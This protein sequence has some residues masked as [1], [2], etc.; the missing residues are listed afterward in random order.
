MPT[1]CHS[2]SVAFQGPANYFHSSIN[3]LFATPKFTLECMQQCIHSLLIE[4]CMLTVRF[5]P[6]T[7]SFTS[8]IGS[9]ACADTASRIV[10]LRSRTEM[11]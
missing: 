7:M 4:T 5:R 1:L 3:A 2:R 11:L 10:A 8:K 6:E 9:D